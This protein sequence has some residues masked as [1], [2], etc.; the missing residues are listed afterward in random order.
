MRG[1]IKKYIGLAG[2]RW[3]QQRRRVAWALETEKIQPC[4]VGQATME[5]Y[6]TASISN[7]NSS[8]RKIF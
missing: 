5:D 8:K 2:I 4:D 6:H 1:R 3:E 7:C